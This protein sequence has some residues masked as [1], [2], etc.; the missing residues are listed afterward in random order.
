MGIKKKDDSIDKVIEEALGGTKV[1]VKDVL[2]RI[3]KYENNRYIPYLR[4]IP[5]NE[6][7]PPGKYRLTE[8]MVA[9][10]D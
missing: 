6:R 10:V 4:N 1:N 3:N 7:I 2:K 5:L 9:H 8:T